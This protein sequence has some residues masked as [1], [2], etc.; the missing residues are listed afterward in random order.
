MLRDLVRTGLPAVAA[1]AAI[2]F[3][4]SKFLSD[5]PMLVRVGG[6]VALAAVTG[7]LFRRR[8]DVAHVAMA[9]IL[10]TL[11]YEGG[12][13]AAGG[14]VAASKAAGM[15]QLAQLI[16]SDPSAMGYLA[17]SLQA[18]KRDVQLGPSQPQAAT[19]MAAPGLD[20]NLA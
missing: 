12:V 17:S 18:Q 8:A 13:R 19:Q 2:G 20:V 5:K 10:G 1:G 15:Q 4:D 3:V 14:V 16:Y 6:K 9:S 7:L 11:G